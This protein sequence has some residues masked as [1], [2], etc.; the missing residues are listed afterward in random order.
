LNPVI[1]AK[2]PVVSREVPKTQSP[3]APPVT[4]TRAPIPA[5]PPNAAA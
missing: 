5:N 3:K 1:P 2:V 4:P